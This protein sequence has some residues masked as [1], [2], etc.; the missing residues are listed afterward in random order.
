MTVSVGFRQTRD[1]GVKI[2]V[3]YV[4][5]IFLREGNRRKKTREQLRSVPT[6]LYDTGTSPDPSN[7]SETRVGSVRER[8]QR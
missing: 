8:S 5:S 7:G 6:E 4:V 3:H 1:F 2:R